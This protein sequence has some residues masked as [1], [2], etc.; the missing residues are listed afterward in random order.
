MIFKQNPREE[1]SN[2]RDEMPEKSC[3][4]NQARQN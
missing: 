1:V 2:M 3:L 4:Q